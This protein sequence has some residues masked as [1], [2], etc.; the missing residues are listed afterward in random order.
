MAFRLKLVPTVTRI[1]FFRGWQF[2]AAFSIVLTLVSLG[3]ALV[4]G[5]N[6]GI[7]FRGGTSIRAESVNPPDLPALRALLE[8]RDLSDVALTEVFDPSFRPDQHVVQIRAS[9]KGEEPGLSPE[10]VTALQLALQTVDPDL[11]FTSAE[12]VSGKVSGELV[13][14]AFLSMVAASAGILLYLWMRFEWQFA[15]GAVLSL[16]HDAVVI[17]GIWSVFGLKFD[18]TTVAAVLTI[19]GYSVNDTVVIFDRVR[20]NLMKFK[21][22]PLRELLNLTIN[23]TLSRTVMTTTTT[24][25]ALL[26][27]L[28]FGGDVIRGFVLAMIIGVVFGVYSTVY[29]ATLTVYL[30]GITRDRPEKKDRGPNP[31]DPYAHVGH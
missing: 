22:M 15:V 4:Q 1:D 6:F 16:V 31:H 27:L 11:T 29:V 30:L 21:Q 8:G 13:W 14:T 7:D 19:I 2:I 3:S 24:L 23:E 17:V 20:E 5:F 18:L 12:S 28:A 26:A 25:L 9:N 10:E